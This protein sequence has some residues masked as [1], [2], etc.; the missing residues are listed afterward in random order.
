MEVSGGKH[1]RRKIVSPSSTPQQ[2]STS[3]RRDRPDDP[4][5]EVEEFKREQQ[6]MIAC[7]RRMQD[8]GAEIVNHES[9]QQEQPSPDN[10]GIIICPPRGGRTINGRVWGSFPH[11]QSE[12]ELSLPAS[13]ARTSHTS[14]PIMIF[15]DTGHCLGTLVVVP[16]SARS[17]SD[18]PY[19]I[20]LTIRQS[21]KREMRII[22]YI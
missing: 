19:S 15:G 3:I 9:R 5:W 13:R 21:S 22:K 11:L 6:E 2:R 12:S 1:G 10:R 18:R 7:F 20:T 8:E 17:I 14:L 16:L 4:R